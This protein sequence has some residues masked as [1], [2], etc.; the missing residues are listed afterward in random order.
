MIVVA[1]KTHFKEKSPTPKS[2]NL[3]FLLFGE[4]ISRRT[5]RQKRSIVEL[6]E[7]FEVR[8]PTPKSP[9]KQQKREAESHDSTSSRKNAYEKWLVRVF[10]YFL[11]HFYIWFLGN[12][13][14]LGRLAIFAKFTKSSHRK[15]CL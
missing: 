10:N 11:K 14:R 15:N 9:T 1:S 8:S 3:D 6:C 13:E 7:H 5:R 2:L 12:L 4:G